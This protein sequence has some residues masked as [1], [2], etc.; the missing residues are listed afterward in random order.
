MIVTTI[1]A[2]LKKMR[3]AFNPGD[4]AFICEVSPGVT[5]VNFKN[6]GQV[7]NV[8]VDMPFADVLAWMRADSRPPGFSAGDVLREA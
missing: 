1:T 6:T 2:A 7:S 3:F 4:V 8:D 5:R